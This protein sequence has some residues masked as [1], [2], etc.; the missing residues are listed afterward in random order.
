[1]LNRFFKKKDG[2]SYHPLNS[3]PASETTL[4]TITTYRMTSIS[5][6]Y[7][8]PAPNT[9]EGQRILAQYIYDVARGTFHTDYEQGVKADYIDKMKNNPLKNEEKPLWVVYVANSPLDENKLQVH[10]SNYA[11]QYENGLLGKPY[12]GEF[13]EEI[14]RWDKPRSSETNQLEKS[15]I[16][17]SE[18]FRPEHLTKLILLSGTPDSIEEIRLDIDRDA[19][20]EVY[21]NSMYA[22]KRAEQDG[23][24]DD[25]ST[26]CLIL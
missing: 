26:C 4:K 15:E 11:A 25:S 5:P 21:E 14:A 10:I 8:N 17:R 7:S 22:R 1:M 12:P 13:S 19:F 20:Q 3:E 2:A 9:K 23:L 16:C 6:R 24:T 18:F